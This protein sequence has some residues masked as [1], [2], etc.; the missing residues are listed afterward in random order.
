M[1]RHLLRRSPACLSAAVP[2]A[3]GTRGALWQRCSLSTAGTAAAGSSQPRVDSTVDPGEVLRFAK[4][5]DQWWAPRGPYVGLHQLNHVRVPIIVEAARRD[6]VAR[7]NGAGAGSLGSSLTGVRLADVGCGGG[8]L[9][10][11]G[12]CRLCTPTHARTRTS[13]PTP[14]LA[15]VLSWI[16]MWQ[17]RMK[18]T[19]LV[20]VVGSG[21]GALGRLCRWRG[22]VPG[23]RRSCQ[24]PPVSQQGRG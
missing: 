17:A 16:A 22:R 14:C 15:Q 5:A 4:L 8:I 21:T 12:Q 2:L 23:E 11:V 7:D 19:S 1:L 13:P 3:P 9:S 6:R 10:E 24:G 20:V 18:H